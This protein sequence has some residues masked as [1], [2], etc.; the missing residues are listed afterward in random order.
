MIW[1]L[2]VVVVGNLYEVRLIFFFRIV[3]L[4]T[5][6]CFYYFLFVVVFF[7][8]S[9]LSYFEFFLEFFSIFGG[10]CESEVIVSFFTERSVFFSE[11]FFF[12]MEGFF[13]I[14]IKIMSMKGDRERVCSCWRR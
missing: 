9:E 7:F 4:G 1:F 12:K 6:I 2:C 11:Y 10:R 3:M 13:F 8:V 14:V 5:K